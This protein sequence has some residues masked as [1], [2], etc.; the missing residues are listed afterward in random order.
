MC[1]N[2]KLEQLCFVKPMSGLNELKFDINLGNTEMIQ[3][4]CSDVVRVEL[5]NAVQDVIL[6]SFAVFICD[7]SLPFKEPFPVVVQALPGMFCLLAKWPAISLNPLWHMLKNY[8]ELWSDGEGGGGVEGVQGNPQLANVLSPV[9]IQLD[10][11]D[12]LTHLLDL[13]KDLKV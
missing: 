13:E 8:V 11:K 1:D 12:C 3:F 10:S 5:C 7:L 4:I 2:R 9:W 6:M